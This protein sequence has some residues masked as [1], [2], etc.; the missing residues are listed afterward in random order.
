MGCCNGHFIKLFLKQF[1]DIGKSTGSLF[2]E[3]IGLFRTFQKLT[4]PKKITTKF[5]RECLS[6]LRWATDIFYIITNSIRT[7]PLS[8]FELFQIYT[9]VLPL[10]ILTFISVI[11]APD[12]PI[13]YYFVY[14]C[15]I[16][17]GAGFGMIGI[18]KSGAIGCCVTAAILIIIS[19]INKVKGVNV[20]RFFKCCKKCCK[21][22]NSDSEEDGSIKYN[23]LIHAVF[24][25]C[26]VFSA[27]IYPIVAPRNK[28]QLIM[29]CVIIIICVFMFCLY[30]ITNGFLPQ[31]MKKVVLKS[32][33][34][35]IG[36]FP[37]LIIPS[38]ERFFMII[39]S[40][41]EGQWTIIASYAAI[42]L[43]LPISITLLM[44]I[45]GTQDIRKKYIGGGYC[46]IE[47]VDIIRQ[48]SYAICASY[49]ILWGC[50]GLEA[51]WIILIIIVRPYTNKSEYSL[52]IG[53]SVVLLI[54]NGSL[55]Y[56]S[57]VPTKLF[58]YTVTIIFIVIACI[59]AILSIYLFFALDFSVNEDKFDEYEYENSVN[60]LSFFAL[61]VTPLAWG[62][63]GLVLPILDNKV[64]LEYDI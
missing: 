22:T 16:M 19:I 63:Y 51:A 9:Y 37:L 31:L 53:N 41:Y 12:M 35:I 48:V 49:D 15:F 45:K 42:A 8:D 39:Q 32:V 5:S 10:T 24:M 56:S 25:A 21:E 11:I 27:T 57:Y 34:F 40:N 54:T 62:F 44:I 59:P 3:I 46:Y 4:A 26:L 47:F 23:L 13:I 61:T 50:A 6:I 7:D 60:T 2:D 20:F 29:I 18:N 55:I 64:D 36:L 52:T 1:L 14:G 58:G 28:V 33:S 17:L 38:T 30:G 43:L